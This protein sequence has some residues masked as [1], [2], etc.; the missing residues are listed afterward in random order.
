MRFE[1]LLVLTALFCGPFA[2][3]GV[4]ASAPPAVRPRTRATAKVLRIVI[5]N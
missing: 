5:L 2:G 1:E 3:A 4:W